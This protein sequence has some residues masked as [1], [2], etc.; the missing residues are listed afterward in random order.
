MLQVHFVPSELFLCVRYAGN[1]ISGL[2]NTLAGD[3]I[4]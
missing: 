2:E 1:K 3:V 4:V